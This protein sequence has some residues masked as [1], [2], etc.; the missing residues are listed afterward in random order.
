MREFLICVDSDGTAMDTMTIKHVRCFGPTII[1]VFNL[2]DYKDKILERWNEIN[3]Y[4]NTR[5]INRFLG[6]K[7]LLEEINE[8]FSIDDL[9]S[10]SE[11]CNITN[12]YSNKDL[13]DYYLEN[14]SP[15]I[16]KVL[17][18][19]NLVNKRINELP[20]EDKK[21]FEG[22]KETLEY[23]SQYADIAIVS[24]ANKNAVKEEWERCHLIE[25][26]SYFMSQE[27]G[28]KEECI[29]KLLAKGYDNNKAIMLGDSI[30]D[31]KASN[32]NNIHYY[33]IKPKKEIES[34]I[35]FKNSIFTSFIKGNYSHK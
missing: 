9:K 20:K 6:L 14:N 18:W 19:S 7:M 35:E 25:Y 8:Y 21:A 2:E 15:C 30:E 4:S 22:V 27:E 26:V 10:Y 11:W 29:K 5:G 12:N 32:L 3:L 24:S 33:S 31:L 34:W 23:I 28:T 13:N 17:E 16:K 1:E